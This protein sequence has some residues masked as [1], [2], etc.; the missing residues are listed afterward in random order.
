MGCVTT[1]HA[2]DSIIKV[3]MIRGVFKHLAR[4]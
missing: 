3:T 2:M 1:A 4:E